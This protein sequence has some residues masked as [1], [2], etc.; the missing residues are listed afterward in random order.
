M[1]RIIFRDAEGHVACD[2][3]AEQLLDI[4]RTEHGAV[5][6]DMQTPSMDEYKSV[7][8][9]T[10]HFHPL[11]IED[12]I[13]DIHLPKIDDYGAYLY[14]VFHT[15]GL[16]Q[17]PMDIETEEVD[18]FLGLNYLITIHDQ[19]RRSIDRAWDAEHHLAS[20][21]ARGPA[22]LLYELLDSQI[23][24]YIPII[25]AFEA[26]LEQLGDDI[27]LSNENER[28]LLNRLLTAKSSS[29]RL[30]R[31]LT[32]QRELLGRLASNE[33]RAIPAPVR[34]YFR[35]VYDH[36]ARLANLAEG[37]RELAGSTIETH[38]ALVNNRLNEI[39]KILTIMSSIF[40]PL[41]FIAGIYG[42]NFE[43]MP[44]LSWRWGYPMIWLV[45]ILVG[46]GLLMFFR[47][48]KWI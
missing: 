11:A 30:Q 12:T 1:I 8:D 25:D 21:L 48:R 22:M 18:V 3:P 47:R 33:Y 24:S 2:L 27:F 44:E 23:D 14:L 7:L 36:L 42:M 17:E 38:L 41:S 40:I 19:P 46:G 9:S 20:G 13:N 6:I 16:G 43:Y 37:T 4:L 10:F 29:L 28:Y 26:Q 15:V 32:P 34:I 31:I 39:M 45:F 35:D 5:W